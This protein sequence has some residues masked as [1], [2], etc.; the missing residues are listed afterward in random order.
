MKKTKIDWCDMTINPVIGCPNGCRYC[1]ARK[2]ND[3]FHFIKDFYIPEIKENAFRP[4]RKDYNVSVFFDSMSDVGTWPDGLC[5]KF[6][7]EVIAKSSFEVFFIGLTKVP[8]K[9]RSVLENIKDGYHNVYLGF[10]CGNRALMGM[11]KLPK[12]IDGISFLSIE[13]LCEDVSGMLS[14][15]LP[16]GNGSIQ[17]V[18][19]GA[20]TGNDKDK[21]ICRKEWVDKIVE[22]CDRNN[23]VVFMKSSLKSIMGTEFRQDELPWPV[24]PKEYKKAYSMLRGAEWEEMDG[25]LS[26]DMRKIDEK[27]MSNISSLT[28]DQLH[29]MAKSD[30]LQHIKGMACSDINKTMDCRCI[31]F[32]L[33]PRLIYK[34]IKQ[35][36]YGW[37]DYANEQNIGKSDD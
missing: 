7:D 13:P 2:L 37:K 4:I 33:T 17:A 5:R 28:D 26:S 14:E 27:E 35:S 18:I 29:D 25:T 11:L 36:C 23:I 24:E 31:V 20:E 6:R 30:Y 9:A 32:L 16:L 3:R 8:S 34:K 10:S 19:I 15:V 1:Y 21:I 22:V 12:F